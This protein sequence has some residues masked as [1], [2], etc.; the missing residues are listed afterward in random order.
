MGAAD[1]VMRTNAVGTVN[2]NRGVLRT[3]AAGSA[4][5]NVA[6]MAAHILP[7][8]FMPMAQFPVALSGTRTAS[9]PRCRRCAKWLPRRPAPGSPMRS[10][11]ASSGGTA[12][13][14]PSGSTPGVCA[15]CPSRRVPSTPR[16]AGSRNRRAPA[17]WWPTP[18]SRAGQGRG[19]GRPAGVLRQRQRP[20]TSPAPTSLNDGGVV[21]SIRERA[22]IAAAN[23]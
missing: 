7:E 16:W 6:S 23:G 14:R 8:E 22:R 9:W 5:V 13:H 1:Y 15:S 10:A 20:A 17:H 19:D 11:R 12:R 2:V 4:I 18:P 21:A 3:A